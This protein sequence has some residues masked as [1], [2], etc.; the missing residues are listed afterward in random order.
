MK[1]ISRYINIKKSR[2]FNILKYRNKNRIDIILQTK[3][4]TERSCGEYH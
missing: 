3:F 2:H 1:G 4:H